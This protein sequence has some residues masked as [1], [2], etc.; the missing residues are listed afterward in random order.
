MIAFTLSVK[1]GVH[2]VLPVDA[3][4]TP[5]SRHGTSVAVN[6]SIVVD[7]VPAESIGTCGDVVLTSFHDNE[8]YA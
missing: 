7:P 8:S 6:A 4:G 3:V 5:A 1:T 2:G